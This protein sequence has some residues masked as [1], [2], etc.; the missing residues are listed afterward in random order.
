MP[1]DDE[2]KHLGKEDSGDSDEADE[3]EEIL[4]PRPPQ[5]SGGKGG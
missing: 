2:Q 5:R 1:N 3:T 4:E